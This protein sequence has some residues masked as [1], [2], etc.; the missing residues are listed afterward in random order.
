MERLRLS[1]VSVRLGV[2]VRHTY[3]DG[4][5]ERCRCPFL[6]QLHSELMGKPSTFVPWSV[7][8]C[9]WLIV[10]YQDEPADVYVVG[11]VRRGE[12][13]IFQ[14][15]LWTNFPVTKS[16]DF[17]REHVGLRWG[18]MRCENWHQH[19]S[20]FDLNT[21]TV[22]SKYNTIL[23]LSMREECIMKSEYFIVD[24]AKDSYAKC[25]A[26]QLREKSHRIQLSLTSSK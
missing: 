3:K 18:A 8:F 12:I 11:T 14:F 15:I 10:C 9:M 19:G 23:L 26:A 5:P 21:L 7:L 13:R 2:L 4:W 17:R 25:F 22:A 16:L 6:H 1:I 24:H 20:L